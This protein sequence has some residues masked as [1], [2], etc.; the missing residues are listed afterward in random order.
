MGG[1]GRVALGPDFQQ[2][3]VKKYVKTGFF[4]VMS[5]VQKYSEDISAGIYILK[6]YKVLYNFF[7]KLRS[8]S[9][10]L[11]LPSPSPVRVKYCLHQ[12]H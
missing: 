1:V 5:D 11:T 7:C 8:K 9:A 10:R 3:Y 12:I 4:D 2:K 6:N